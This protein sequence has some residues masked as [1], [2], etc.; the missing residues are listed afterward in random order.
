MNARTLP[1]VSTLTEQ[2]QRGWHCVWC[3]SRLKVG[4]DID[5]GEQRARPVRGAAYSWFPRACG[6]AAAC[7]TRQVVVPQ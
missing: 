2:Q 3:G 4:D 6:D 7:A 1:P 5:L